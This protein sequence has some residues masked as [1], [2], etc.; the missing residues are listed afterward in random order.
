MFRIFVNTVKKK[1]MLV[2]ACLMLAV[3][4]S[5]C[6]QSAESAL[7]NP[8]ATVVN[9][10]TRQPL[11][12]YSPLAN[13]QYVSKNDT[14]I[15][16]FGPALNADN[17]A[18]LVV[19]PT[20]AKSGLHDGKLILADDRRTVI[21][22]PNQAFTPGEQVTV[23][24][25][26][27]SVSIGVA[28]QPLNYSF[29]VAANQQTAVVASNTVP[30]T[31]PVPAFPAYLTLPKDIPHYTVSVTSTSTLDEGYIFVSP[32]YWTMS[33][34]GSYLLILDNTGQIVYYK[35]MADQLAGF[36]FKVLPSGYMVY[37]DQKTSLH[38]IMDSHYQVVGTYAAQNGYAADLHDFLMTKD[39]YTFLMIADEE[40]IDMSK[41]VRGGQ[42]DAA[43]TGLVIQE[44]DPHQNVIFEWR[45]WDHFTFGESTASLTTQ[46]IDL[47]HGNGLALSNDGNLLLSCRNL[48]SITKI[49]LQTGAIMWRF[50][51]KRNDFKLVN[52]SGFNFQHNI[53]MLANGDITLFD[54]QGTDQSPATSRALEY[55]LDEANKT[56]NLVWSFA[57][58]PPVFTDYM[59]DVQRMAN[60]NTFIAWGSAVVTNGYVFTSMTEVA[61]DN[62]VIFEMAFDQ[63]YV[64]YRAFRGPWVGTPSSVPD[65]AY[66]VGDGEFTL[67]YSWNGT[68]EVASWNL[69]G[70]TSTQA[71]IL[72]DQR[73]KQGFETQSHF[74]DLPPNECYFQVAA[75]DKN[76]SELA[77]SE[78]LSTD[79]NICPL[80]SNV[81]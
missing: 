64:S 44:L 35:S 38:V 17:L 76:G 47:I 4:L 8:T 37:Y 77:R 69:Y 49:D 59:G 55:R 19:S 20:G 52:D 10:P 25:S 32:F 3:A 41:M 22:K 9:E 75:L 50:G 27:L 45:S 12:Y 66:S 70:G 48:S 40:T 18:N 62:Q 14:I 30:T 5:A 68:T 78:L 65:L 36:D 43:V 23:Q 57:H 31:M 79:K 80:G 54:N 24:V 42:N 51:G 72:I 26:S 28:Y 46:Q 13:A 56:A 15:L 11:A 16:R 39:G 71:M 61:P 53:A 58:N 34:V 21:F 81:R 1:K 33:T 29:T 7:A 60:G 67:G 63:P 2:V 73:V 74:A 6:A